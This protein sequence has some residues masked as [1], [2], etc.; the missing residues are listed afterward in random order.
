MNKDILTI[1]L[2]RSIFPP[3]C[4]GGCFCLFFLFPLIVIC[5]ELIFFLKVILQIFYN[6]VYYI[7]LTNV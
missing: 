3:R 4:A 6:D 5:E 2:M 7:N 1:M